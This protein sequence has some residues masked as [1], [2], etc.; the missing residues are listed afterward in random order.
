MA[1]GVTPQA[2]V[3]RM[4]SG[5]TGPEDSPGLLR[6]RV[7]A[8]GVALVGAA[9]QRARQ[10]HRDLRPLDVGP[11]RDA[12]DDPAAERGDVDPATALVEARSVFADDVEVV[13]AGAV[14]TL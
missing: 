2:A 14:Y 3:T 7:P 6:R 4:F 8:A 10:S 13:E 1:R 12:A 9:E 11:V 5:A